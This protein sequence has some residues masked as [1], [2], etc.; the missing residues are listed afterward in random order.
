MPLG[1]S[2]GRNRTSMA[3]EER[4]LSRGGRTPLGAVGERIVPSVVCS[5]PTEV[6]QP[7]TIPTTLHYSDVSN[8]EGSILVSF[9]IRGNIKL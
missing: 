7:I 8:T 9:Y 3:E 1:V 5:K 4:A 2:G 6:Q